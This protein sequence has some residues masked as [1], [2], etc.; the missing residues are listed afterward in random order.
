MKKKSLSNR[1]RVRIG[2][3]VK[4]AKSDSNRIQ[5][6]SQGVCQSFCSRLIRSN[7]EIYQVARQIEGMI[8]LHDEDKDKDEDGEDEDY[9][10]WQ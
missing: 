9:V 5:V 3:G 4:A 10:G 7:R 6:R 8:Y 1:I 2:F